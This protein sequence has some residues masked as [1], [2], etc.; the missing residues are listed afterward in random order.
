VDS[1]VLVNAIVRD[2][3]ER[4]KLENDR[5]ELFTRETDA[6]RDAEKAN[7]VKDEFLATL[8]HELRT[9]L[10]TILSWAQILRS[11]KIGAEKTE[12]AIAVIERSAKDQGQLIDDLLDVSRIQAGKIFLELR[13]IK[14][15]DYIEAALESVRSLAEAKSLSLQTEFDP[16]AGLIVG[17]SNRL[18]QV[19][20][21]LFTNAIKFTPPGGKITVRSRRTKD[22]D[23]L[24]VQV[25]D[26]GR[27]IKP[28]FLPYL[29]TRFSQEDS[30]T[31]RAFG[32][33]GLG[34]SIVQ[35]LV[36]MHGGTVTASS[37][38]EGKGAVFTVSL[39]C[40][41]R[42]TRR[43][44][45]SKI[46]QPGQK[47]TGRTA[48]SINVKGL[49]VLIIDDLEDTREAFSTLLESHGV[50]VQAVPSAAKGLAA[51]ARF[52]PDVVLC[53]IAMPGEDG[54]S[55]IR[56]A[57]ALRPDLGGKTPAVALTAYAEAE[58]TRKSLAAGFDAHLAKPPD[59]TDLCR[60]IA[61][62]AGRL[63]K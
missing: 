5:Q 10:T 15:I 60:L 27:G 7:L 58:S 6:R 38:G 14:L 47:A 3:S 13:P 45:G 63:K 41:A 52:K 33:L 56:K 4:K 53:D 42:Q 12:H 9:P 34:L 30:T 48:E 51:L 36:Q 18:Q 54:F 62:L 31:K 35:D 43:E 55:F 21:N 46:S 37:P 59:G 8:S 40:M 16:S 20:R 49:R 57:R 26:T 50:K 32:G 61:T 39:P 1:K 19:F 25:E 28:Q 2:V 24:E 17:D 11:R 44:S 23:R 22:P 29:F